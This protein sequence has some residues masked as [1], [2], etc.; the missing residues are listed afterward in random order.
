MNS[1]SPKLRVD[2]PI[3]IVT[4]AG[5]GNSFADS[6]KFFKNGLRDGNNISV[7]VTMIKDGDIKN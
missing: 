4:K 6:F 2:I 3:A 5:L 1:F 7:E